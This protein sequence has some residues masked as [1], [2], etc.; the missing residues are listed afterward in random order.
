MISEETYDKALEVLNDIKTDSRLSNLRA[1][2]MLSLKEKGRS[3]GRYHQ[4]SQEKFDNLFKFAIDN[5]IGCGFDSCSAAKAFNFIDKNP[6][7]DY[8]RTY[9]EP[10][11]A[12]GKYSSYL[13]VDCNYFP[14]SFAEGNGDWETG[15]SVL[16]CNDFMEDI[17]FNQKTK[18]FGNKVVN[19]RKCNIGC[20][21]YEI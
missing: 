10:C 11:E 9:I 3:V 4:L 19:C 18:I 21:I 2:V 1:L 15:L 14:C 8:M 20:P 12:G 17:W 5:G 16:N 7:Y 6:Q 13:N